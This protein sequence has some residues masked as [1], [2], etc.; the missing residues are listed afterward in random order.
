MKWINVKEMLPVHDDEVLLFCD[1][2]EAIVGKLT[3]EGW[4]SGNQFVAWD[5]TYNHG[6]DI[7]HW[8][9]LPPPPE[10]V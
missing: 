10:D 8:M 4:V 9:P 5:Y 2:G 1:I 7:T 6:V 3:D